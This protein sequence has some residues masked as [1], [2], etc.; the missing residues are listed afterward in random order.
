MANKYEKALVNLIMAVILG[1]SLFLHPMV[2]K[3]SPV[4]AAVSW[5]KSTEEVTLDNELYVTDAWVIKEDTTYKMWY[6]HGKPTLTVDEIANNLIDLDIGNL[7][8]DIAN[9]DFGQFFSHLSVLNAADLL[10]FADNASTVIGY[11]TSSDGMTWSIANSLAFEGAGGSSWRGV[12]APCVIKDDDEV[13]PNKRYKMWYANSGTDLNAVNLQSI[14]TDLGS[15]DMNVVRA[16]ILDLL[17][18]TSTVIGYATSPDGDTWTEQSSNVLASTDNILSSLGAPCVIKDGTTYKMWYTH[19]KTGLNEAELGSILADIDGDTFDIDDLWS[20]LGSVSTVVGYA[21][22]PDGSNWTVEDSEVLTGGG[23]LLN[24]VADPSVIKNDTTYEMWYTNGTTNLTAPTLQSLL[25]TIVGLDFPALWT[26]L[27]DDGLSDFIDAF[28]DLDLNA[29]KSSL[30][31]TSTVIGYATSDNGVD[32]TV[33]NPQNLTGSSITP[34]SSVAAP[35]V[36]KSGTKYEMWYTEGI[37]DIT[38][39]DIFDLVY[40]ADLPIGYASYKPSGG[41][42]GA[43]LPFQLKIDLLGIVDWYS[44]NF[45]GQV[46]GDIECTSE[47]GKLTITIPANTIALD[48]EKSVLLEMVMAVEENPPSPPPDIVIVGKAY[49]FEPGGATFNPSMIITFSYRL[50]E[51]VDEESLFIAYY[52]ADVGAWVKLGGIL[53][54]EANTISIEVSHLTTFAVFGTESLAPSPPPSTTPSPPPPPLPAAFDLSTLSIIPGEVYTDETIDISVSL[55]NTGGS[56]GSYEVILKINGVVEA[57]REVTLGAGASEQITFTV[58]K[59]V[60]DTYSVDVSG[61]TGSFIVKEKTEEPTEPILPPTPV[62]VNWWLIGGIIAGV[63][64]IGIAIWQVFGYRR[65]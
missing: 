51:N 20:I 42:G 23:N 46:L 55:T 43:F 61:L 27:K 9:L 21:T 19:T 10:E 53:D 18:G 8:N 28:L 36:V 7:I 3:V 17:D 47:D 5:T 24:S 38:L 49:N 64:A 52:D 54:M 65:V 50:P 1:F 6:T 15:S 48:E 29:F 39:Q 57:T 40:G 62:V 56:V 44:I 13:D 34:W 16:A 4:Q 58:S 12:G 26:T 25:D 31:A 63:I 22:S 11:A 32:W 45:L 35:C 37:D 30:A 33:G 60:A 41:M 14:L 2:N 59:D